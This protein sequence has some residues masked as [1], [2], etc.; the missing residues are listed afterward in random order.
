MKGSLNSTGTP[1]FRAPAPLQKTGKQLSEVLLWVMR[2]VNNA[3]GLLM[4]RQ[5]GGS[6][7]WS[8]DILPLG[9]VVFRDLY[10]YISITWEV[11]S[12]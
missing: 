10:G 1:S 9:P 6:V 12:T 5:T 11:M 4:T 8:K 2:L 3:L 7:L